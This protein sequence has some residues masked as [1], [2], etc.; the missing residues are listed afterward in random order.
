MRSNFKLLFFLLPAAAL[1]W[2][3]CQNRIPSAIT[4]SVTGTPT[5]GAYPAPSSNPNRT[6]IANFEGNTA[7]TPEPTNVTN[8]K[9]F[10]LGGLNNTI[11]SPGGWNVTNNFPLYENGI[12]LIESTFLAP[13]GTNG[14]SLACHLSGAV[15]DTG[16]GTYPSLSLDGFIDTA[17]PL[18]KNAYNAGF[19]T[20]IKFMMNISP[21]DTSTDRH[22]FIP[23]LQEAPPP[24]GIC[25]AGSACYNFF[26]FTFTSGTNGWKQFTFNFTDLTPTPYG[27]I[28]T[29]PTF[30]G[31]NLQEVLWLRWQSGR[32]NTAGTSTVDFWVDE[33]QF[34]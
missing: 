30:T 15:T 1:I 9:L 22:F 4:T 18:P 27:L 7:P 34:Y 29:P 26:G 3:G 28:P 16:N 23:T 12:L 2:L 33:V 32:A 6:L 21:A 11:G 24:Q 20:G 13:G 8:S 19:F 25:G 17:S 10:E 14:T 31:V 5:P